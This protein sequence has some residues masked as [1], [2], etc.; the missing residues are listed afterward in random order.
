MNTKQEMAGKVNFVHS[1]VL[2]KRAAVWFNY[3]IKGAWEASPNPF[4]HM[5]YCFFYNGPGDVSPISTG[6]GHISDW[7]KGSAETPYNLAFYFVWNSRIL[8]CAIS[9]YKADE[10]TYDAAGAERR[11]LGK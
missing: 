4:D 10:L 8:V 6:L 11:S 7:V 3:A 9:V 5:L 2:K 1:S